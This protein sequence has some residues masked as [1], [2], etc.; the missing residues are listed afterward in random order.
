MTA[1]PL[2]YGA[3]ALLIC[4]LAG[5]VWFY[6]DEGRI[7]RSVVF[8]FFLTIAL[9]VALVLGVPLVIIALA[10]DADVRLWQAAIAGLVIATGWLTTAIFTEQGKVRH[11][12]ERLR[13]YH[14]AI[15]AEIG[16]SV[17]ALWNEGKSQEHVDAMVVRMEAEPDFVPFIPR[18]QHD[19]IYDAVVQEIDVLP[20]Q[21]IDAIVAYYG[22]IKAIGALANDMR[23]AGFAALGPDRR[24]L[25]YRDY[26]EMR[27]QAF[28]FGQ[29]A[30]QLILAYSN[31]GADAADA[32]IKR[33]SSRVADPSDLSQGSV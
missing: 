20:R 5:S 23:G 6:G 3:M 31:G 11:K 2:L 22:Q 9:P 15:Y 18:E 10:F 19:H 12:A 30:L 29:Y 24:V 25:M 26:G 33:V 7:A 21:T 4:L 13:D 8:R 16:N 32:V 28:A 17:D 14:K 27:K 1:S